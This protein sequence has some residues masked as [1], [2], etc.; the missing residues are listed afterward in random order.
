MIIT[1]YSIILSCSESYNF[2]PLKESKGACQAEK[3]VDVGGICLA[4]SNKNIYVS[5]GER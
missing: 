5:G 1:Q 4:D 2:M 3:A